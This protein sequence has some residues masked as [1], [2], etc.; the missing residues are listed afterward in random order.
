MVAF[1]LGGSEKESSTKFSGGPTAS[2]QGVSHGSQCLTRTRHG[3][4]TATARVTSRPWWRVGPTLRASPG[5]LS[6]LPVFCHFFA[7]GRQTFPTKTSGLRVHFLPACHLQ[8]SSGLVVSIQILLARRAFCSW[9]P[10]QVLN[11]TE[12]ERRTSALTEQTHPQ[13]NLRRP[14]FPYRQAASLPVR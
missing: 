9:F 4:R 12:A 5:S 8:G 10:Q 11:R 13:A 2:A 7:A 6:C 14:H 1:G 3:T